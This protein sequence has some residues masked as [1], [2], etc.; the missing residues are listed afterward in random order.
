MREQKVYQI[1]KRIFAL[2]LVLCLCVSASP[3]ET[4][5]KKAARLNY[6]KLTITCGGTTKKLK[7]V[8]DNVSK[9]GKKY[10]FT[11]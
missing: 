9:D 7:V 8:G 2:V 10:T 1:C 3:Y 5:A 4:F 11:Y 6:R